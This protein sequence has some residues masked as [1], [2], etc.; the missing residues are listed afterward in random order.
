MFTFVAEE[1]HTDRAV[2]GLGQGQ[3]ARSRKYG[4]EAEQRQWS[5]EHHC[6]RAGNVTPQL[7]GARPKLRLAGRFSLINGP[8]RW[9]FLFVGLC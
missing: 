3:T 2:S 5:E 4:G 7:G 8:K 1:E 6:E 9:T